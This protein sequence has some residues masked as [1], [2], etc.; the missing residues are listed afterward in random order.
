MKRL[1][2]A[3]VIAC[4]AIAG[5]ARA[6]QWGRILPNA[7]VAR[8]QED[9][10]TEK[11]V[12][13][14]KD[15]IQAPESTIQPDSGYPFVDRCGCAKS[16]CD[17]VWAGYSRHCGCGHSRAHFGHHGH[18][19]G[20]GHA[21]R[22]KCCVVDTCDTGCGCAAGGYF[23]SFAGGG[24]CSGCGCGHKLGLGWHAGKLHALGGCGCHGRHFHHLHGL[25]RAC[26]LGCDS[27]C[28]CCDGSVP[29]GEKQIM[30]PPKVPEDGTPVVERAPTLAPPSSDKSALRP[31]LPGRAI[32]GGY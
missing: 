26:G 22:A 31:W 25:W 3:L 7:L 13:D 2:F 19:C 6:D 29:N 15:A 5:T 21:H 17:N 11:Q 30:N 14:S 16:C 8:F 20:C 27:A 24:C 12:P 10:P 1:L 9:A 4:T 23:N 18:R 32:L 28:D